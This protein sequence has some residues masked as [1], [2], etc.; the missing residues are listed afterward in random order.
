[1]QRSEQANVEVE[2]NL[3]PQRVVLGWRYTHQDA[4]IRDEGSAFTVSL[5]RVFLRTDGSG[6]DTGPRQGVLRAAGSSSLCCVQTPRSNH[7]RVLALAT[8]A[9]ARSRSTA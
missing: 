1:E 9:L 8:A 5:P 4:R 6:C 2:H 3:V 7:Q